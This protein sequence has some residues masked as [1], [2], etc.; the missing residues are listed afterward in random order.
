MATYYKSSF[1]S[2]D[3]LLSILRE[4]HVPG[5][6]SSI[7]KGDAIKGDVICLYDS[8]SNNVANLPY[9]TGY[10]LKLYSSSSVYITTWA[11]GLL[12]SS[13]YIGWIVGCDN[14]F[15]ID[16]YAYNHENNSRPFALLC[17]FTQNGKI[18]FIT[19]SSDNTGTTYRY[20]NYLDH[21]AFG[22][23]L[24]LHTLTT[25]TPASGN[26]TITTPFITNSDDGSSSFTPKAFYMPMCQNYGMG[27]GKFILD[28]KTYITNGYWA[29]DTEPDE[30]E[31]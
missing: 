15:I 22:D 9:S 17:S 20:T 7:I 13:S 30:E 23:S 2:V 12:F 18:A 1:T 3:Q 28:G 11:F 6:F 29:I 26:Q 31:T 14:G 16:C 19:N 27:V 5:M 21:V 4:H 8:D 10:R 25:F 24:S